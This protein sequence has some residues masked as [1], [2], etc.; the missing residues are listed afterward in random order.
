MKQRQQQRQ[1]QKVTQKQTINTPRQ[2]NL[3]IKRLQRKRTLKRGK[4]RTATSLQQ[5]QT[6]RLYG[7]VFRFYLCNFCL[8]FS[9]HIFAKAYQVLRILGFKRKSLKEISSSSFSLFFSSFRFLR[10]LFLFIR[11]LMTKLR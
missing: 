1:Q 10:R 2:R 3:T 7:F 9:S 11:Y 4:I 8:F 5:L 6:L